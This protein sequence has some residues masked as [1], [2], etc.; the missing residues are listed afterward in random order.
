MFKQKRWAAL[1][2]L[3]TAFVVFGQ[4]PGAPDSSGAFTG[5]VYDSEDSIPINGA[6]VVLSIYSMNPEKV[7]SVITGTN[8]RYGFDSL[9][10]G[11]RNSYT[12]TV[13]VAGYAPASVSGLTLTSEQTDIV[14]IYLSADTATPPPVNVGAFTGKVY[15]SLSQQPIS[16]AL[17]I[18]SNRTS[19]A[20]ELVDSARTGVSGAY[21]FDNVPATALI[22]Y[23]ISVSA[24]GYAPESNTGLYADS[25]VTDTV[26]FYLTSL[27]TSN[28]WL[29]YGIITRDS[30][31]G[32]PLAGASVEIVQRSGTEFRYSATT[33][34][35]GRYSAFLLAL[36]RSYAFTVSAAGYITKETISR[37]SGDSTRLDMFL[38]PDTS[39]SGLFRGMPALPLR[40]ALELFPNPANALAPLYVD[41]QGDTPLRIDLYNAVGQNVGSTLINRNLSGKCRVTLDSGHLPSGLYIVKASFEGRQEIQR[42]IFQR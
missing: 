1:A 23:S 31:K 28:G 10:T 15:D 27:D 36:D 34:A 2:V 18:L 25:G 32:L 3:L 11:Q 30:L 22:R 21:L 29:V 5:T 41:I 6:K 17:V 40:S 19:T 16:G 7:D 13:T 26:D 39:G 20:W 42:L 35:N 8:G 24:Q 12:I 9:L 37:V 38:S 4:G 14:D 33:D